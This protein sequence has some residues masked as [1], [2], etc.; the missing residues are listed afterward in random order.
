MSSCVPS[1]A[2]DKP[3]FKND[4][5]IILTGTSFQACGFHSSIVDTDALF[6]LPLG[7]D[8]FNQESFMDKMFEWFVN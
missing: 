3:H 4:F 1:S 5:G 7:D 6:I 2:L 8:I